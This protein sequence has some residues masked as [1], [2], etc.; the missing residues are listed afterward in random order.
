MKNKFILIFRPFSKNSDPEHSSVKFFGTFV[1]EVWI[2]KSYK[3]KTHFKG[4]SALVIVLRDP[5]GV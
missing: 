2:Q 5:H 4:I 3:N 1:S